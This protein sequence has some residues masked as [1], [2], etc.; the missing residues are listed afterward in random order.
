MKLTR[1]H[2]ANSNKLCILIVLVGCELSSTDNRNELSS[3]DNIARGLGRDLQAPSWHST[4]YVSRRETNENLCKVRGKMTLLLKLSL[5]KKN[6]TLCLFNRFWSS[7]YESRLVHDI[8]SMYQGAK[9]MRIYAWVSFTAHV[10]RRVAKW[11][12]Y[13]NES[14]LYFFTHV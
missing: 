11:H 5:K 9:Q 12:C 7:V 1:P 10:S 14:N 4:V 8:H 2:Y 6:H 13:S 3:T